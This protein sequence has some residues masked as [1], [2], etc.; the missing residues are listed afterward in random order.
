QRPTTNEFEFRSPIMVLRTLVL[1]LITI[2]AGT[3][4]ALLVLP[5]WLPQ[6]SASLA[7]ADPKGYWYLARV[8]ALV[9][10]VL[11]W[12]SMMLGL[13][14][15]NRLAR[16]WPGGPAAFDLHQHASLLGLA[17]ALFHAL[18]L[19]G[20]HYMNYTLAQILTPFA[21][22]AYRLVWVGL[23]QIGLYLMA[24]VGLSFFVRGV[25]GRRFWRIIHYASFGM[26]LLALAHG[27]FSGTDSAA[28]WARALY[29]V[30][31]GSVLFLAIYRGLAAR[32]APRASC[33]ETA[34]LGV[35]TERLR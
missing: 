12:L 31:G 19:L 9:A 22:T 11:L 3:I 30:S 25:T 6:V 7:G 24:V 13:S 21:S 28:A 34:V 26:F 5:A 17:F 14:M 18:V 2:A 33:R 16:A 27:L 4:A 29:W 20:D 1:M 23:G 32:F 10:Y 35:R 8:S 15:T